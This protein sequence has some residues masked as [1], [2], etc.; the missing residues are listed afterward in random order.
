MHIQPEPRIKSLHKRHRTRS[1]TRLA[2]TRCSTF[3]VSRN[4]PHQDAT[5]RSKRSR[6]VRTHKPH[7]I[8]QGQHPLPHRRSIRDHVIHQVR[9]RRGHASPTA[10]R[11]ESS[12]LA[13]EGHYVVLT[14]RLAPDPRKAM[15]QDSTTQECVELAPTEMRHVAFVR[16]Q[17]RLR[18]SPLGLHDPI[19]NRALWLTPLPARLVP[20][21]VNRG[22]Q[23]LAVARTAPVGSGSDRG[24]RVNDGTRSVNHARELSESLGG[25]A[26]PRRHERQSTASPRRSAQRLRTAPH[27]YACCATT[28]TSHPHPKTTNAPHGYVQGAVDRPV[29][30]K[31]LLE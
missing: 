7:S 10:R 19:Q 30:P 15:R 31:W 3:V 21:M 2:E 28:P 23:S 25:V 24:M 16:G 13:G 5:H 8:R 9:R 6:I 20:H 1:R 17:L 27:Q 12:P 22:Q 4:C 18:R 14:T 29:R 26:A 11:A